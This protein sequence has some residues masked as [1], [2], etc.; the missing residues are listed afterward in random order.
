MG[1]NF[2][3]NIELAF[4]F[5]K[6]FVVLKSLTHAHIDVLASHGRGPY[7]HILEE[8]MGNGPIQIVPD[9]EL[10]E[11]FWVDTELNKIGFTD[12]EGNKYKYFF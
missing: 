9:A 5:R 8:G 10:N 3:N 12:Y 7:Y 2:Q 6:L 1:V 11:I 4:I